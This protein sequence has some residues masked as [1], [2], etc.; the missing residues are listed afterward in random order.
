MKS[1]VI[2]IALLALLTAATGVVYATKDT[3]R[4]L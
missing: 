4:R 2:R 3:F 1:T